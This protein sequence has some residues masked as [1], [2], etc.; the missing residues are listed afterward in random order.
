M[1]IHKYEQMYET[2]LRTLKKSGISEKNKELILKFNDELIIEGLSKPR[3]ILYINKLKV[4][5]SEE[6]HILITTNPAE[7][8]K[9]SEKEKIEVKDNKEDEKANLDLNK[10]VYETKGL[11]LMQV[12]ML[13]NHGYELMKAHNLESGPFPYYVKPRHPESKEH[14]FLVTIIADEIQKYT[15]EIKIYQTKKP[16]IIFKNKLGQKIAL[17]IETGKKLKFHKNRINE[18]F[19]T[20]KKK[21]GDRGYIVLTTN[22]IKN[23]YTRYG[24]SILLRQEIKDFV[25][26]QFSGQKNSVIDNDLNRTN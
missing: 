11:T 2:E 15:D 18:K 12:N 24:I 14:T 13:N 17:E 21:Y 5:A 19:E 25:Q 22:R 20:I 3:L 7:M 9:E 4:L 1:D 16:D 26:L 8:I 6:E 10:P 23:S